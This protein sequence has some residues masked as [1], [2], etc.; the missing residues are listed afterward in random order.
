M[1]EKGERADHILLEC[2]RIVKQSEAAHH[3][4]ILFLE[5]KMS[6]SNKI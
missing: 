3:L 2:Q 6:K 1:N 5:Q 4:N